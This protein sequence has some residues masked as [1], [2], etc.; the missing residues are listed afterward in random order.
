M[1]EKEIEEFLKAQARS[2]R[3]RRLEMLQSDLTGTKKLLG[4]VLLP[5]L[6]N[7]DGVTL[8]FEMMSTTG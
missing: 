6:K 3:G 7:F 5:V 1:F 2:A 4:S 8:E